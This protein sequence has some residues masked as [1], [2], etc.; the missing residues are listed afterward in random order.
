MYRYS[1]QDIRVDCQLQPRRDRI[2]DRLFVNTQVLKADLDG[3]MSFAQLLQHTKRS[4]LEA[5]A[6][7]TCPSSSWSRRCN[8][9]VP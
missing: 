7:R 1:G 4:R 2:A 9:N 6:H 8:R 5:Q 3:Q